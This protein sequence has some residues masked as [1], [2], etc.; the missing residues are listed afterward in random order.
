[1]PNVHLSVLN[2]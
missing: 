1:V 2:W